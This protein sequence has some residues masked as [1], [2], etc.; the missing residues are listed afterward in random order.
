MIGHYKHI[1][2]I[3]INDFD[4]LVLKKKLLFLPVLEIKLIFQLGTTW[5]H[6]IIS[7]SFIFG[8]PKH[9][10]FFGI[11]DIDAMVSQ[12]KLDFLPFLELK[13]IFQLG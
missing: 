4:A 6:I 7:F 3:G 11:N 1:L 13:F 9:I 12:E 8:H 5:I 10:L 2:L